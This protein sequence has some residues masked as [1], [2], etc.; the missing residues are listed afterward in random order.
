MQL[1]TIEDII[2]NPASANLWEL[3]MADFGINTRTA[4]HLF[5]IMATPKGDTLAVFMARLDLWCNPHPLPPWD[6][7]QAQF[8]YYRDTWRPAHANAKRFAVVYGQ[9]LGVV[10]TGVSK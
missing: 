2:A 4:G 8:A 3:G 9:A 1:N 7:E 10:P 5:E 6:D